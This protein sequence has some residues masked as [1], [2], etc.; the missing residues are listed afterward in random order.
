MSAR[1]KGFLISEDIYESSPERQK[2]GSCSAQE[3]KS[4]QPPEIPA[5]RICCS[6][7]EEED[8]NT[9]YPISSHL[10]KEKKPKICSPAEGRTPTQICS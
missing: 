8:T 2:R 10:N 3:V 4:T 1:A 6:P 7:A 9:Q 5:T